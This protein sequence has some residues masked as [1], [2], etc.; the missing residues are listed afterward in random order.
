MNQKPNSI[1]DD[2][3]VGGKITDKA[4][5][6]KAS[7]MKE[8]LKSPIAMEDI[9]RYGTSKPFR[10]VISAVIKHGKG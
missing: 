3:Y 6:I 7:E 5:P 9:E 8:F 1:F 2:A 4:T 10:V